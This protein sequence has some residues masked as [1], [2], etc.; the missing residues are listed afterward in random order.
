MKGL[1]KG[2]LSLMLLSA[3]GW[4][5]TPLSMGIALADNA[6]PAT[7]AA[8]TA[9]AKPQAKPAAKKAVKKKVAKK[10][11]RTAHKGAP[12]FVGSITH[13][14]MNASPMTITVVKNAGKKSEF[15][16]GGDLS[17]RTVVFKG[18]KKVG[19]SALQKGQ[20]VVLRYH[21]THESIAVTAIHIR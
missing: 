13:I 15:V 9:P 6:A 10:H 3:L 17:S 12:V 5:V 20:R 21:R 4:T 19:M 7:P 16:F 14:D 2:L 18:R 11:V 1:K 8:K